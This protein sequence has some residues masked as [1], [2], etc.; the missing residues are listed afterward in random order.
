KDLFF[1]LK[2]KEYAKIKPRY[3]KFIE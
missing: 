3:K 1:T 2:L